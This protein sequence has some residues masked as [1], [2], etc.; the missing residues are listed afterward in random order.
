MMF[1]SAVLINTFSVLIGSFIGTKL[2]NFIPSRVKSVL[3]Q[4]VGLITLGIGVSMTLKGESFLIILFSLLA[5]GLIGELLEI[6]RRLQNLANVVEKSEGATPFAKGFVTA[7]VLF[8]VGPMTII[9]SLDIGLR[10]DPNLILVKSLMDFISS[11]IL[12]SMYGI[13]VALSSAWVFLFQGSLVS[14]SR[15]LEFLSRPE[16]LNDFTGLG[17]L[18]ILAIGIRILELRDIK[19]GNYLPA[20]FIIPI[21]DWLKLI[22]Q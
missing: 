2:G 7:S 8:T 17:G 15:A 13:G 5:G 6:E 19:V 18:M 16:Y 21:F 3:F 9:G 20:L 22:L 4:S 14:F 12:S 1:H 11:I 10:G